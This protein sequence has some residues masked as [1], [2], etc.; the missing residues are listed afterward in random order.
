[1][2]NLIFGYI[3][4]KL[5]LRGLSTKQYLLCATSGEQ[6]LRM[7]WVE[8]K[9]EYLF[10]MPVFDINALSENQKNAFLQLYDRVCELRFKVLPQEFAGP[11][12]RKTID[13]E[14]C[15]ILGLKLRLEALYQLLS[16]EPILTG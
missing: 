15:R 11:S 9:K 5:Y 7:G 8:S 10:G 6:F 3:N 13:E 2:S 14:I 12:T 1:M 16:K 4:F